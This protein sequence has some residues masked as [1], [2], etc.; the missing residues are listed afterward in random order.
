[1]IDKSFTINGHKKNH[2]NLIISNIGDVGQ[3][4][5]KGIGVLV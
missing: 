1:M 4:N 5:I 3:A 2:N